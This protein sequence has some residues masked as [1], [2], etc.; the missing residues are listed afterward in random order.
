MSALGQ[1]PTSD[2][3]CG[4]SALPPKADIVQHGGNVPFVPEPDSCGAAPLPDYFVIVTRKGRQPPV[5]QWR[6]C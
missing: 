4:M 1:K 3:V 2:P 6:G 5:E